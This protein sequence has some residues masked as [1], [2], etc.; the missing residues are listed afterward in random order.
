[1]KINYNYS[2][3]F[4]VNTNI[5]SN[6]IG[7]SI[8]LKVLSRICV[9]MFNTAWCKSMLKTYQHLDFDIGWDLEI[10]LPQ[11]DATTQYVCLSFTGFRL[12]LFTFTDVRVYVDVVSLGTSLDKVL[13]LCLTCLLNWGIQGNT[14]FTTTYLFEI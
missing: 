12:A 3:Y 2:Y 10:H 4:A 5:K 1:M 9:Y 13:Q 11:V 8:F 6:T 14:M 7:K